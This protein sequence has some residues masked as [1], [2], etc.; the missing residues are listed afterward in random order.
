MAG[1]GTA[2]SMTH[3]VETESRVG[4]RSYR[5]H[6]M[7]SGALLTATLL[8]TGCGGDVPPPESMTAPIESSYQLGAGDKIRVSVFGDQSL[9]G[10]RQIDG[11]GVFNFPLIGEIKAA[12]QTP[13]QLQ[14]TLEKRLREYMK[15]PNVVVEILTYRP[16]YI[17]GEV[18]RPGSYPFV[19]RMTV[20]NAVAIAG[21]FTYRAR[22]QSFVIQRG[23]KEQQNSLEAGQATRI[24]PGDVVVV[25]ERYF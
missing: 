21:G 8:V 1:I 24:Q 10:E 11:S 13:D 4:R 25:R 12:G 22:E 23:G 6:S 3:A 5:V 2:E 19:D 16:F 18:R 20:I 7:V 14:G 15:E 9:S 17:V